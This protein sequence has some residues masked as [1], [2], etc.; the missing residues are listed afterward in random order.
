MSVQATRIETRDG[1]CR[2]WLFTPEAGALSAN[3]ALFRETLN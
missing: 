2:S 1:T 3:G